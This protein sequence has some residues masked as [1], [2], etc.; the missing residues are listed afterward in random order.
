MYF[1]NIKAI[2]KLPDD[3]RNAI[4]DT[5]NLL[6]SENIPDGKYE[7]SDKNY[8]VKF[9]TNNRP[10]NDAKQEIHKEYIDIH[11]ILSGCEV[12]GFSLNEL[13]VDDDKLNSDDIAFGQVNNE[14]H[15]ELRAN[16]FAIF[17][18]YE[19][20]KPICAIEKYQEVDDISKIVIKVSA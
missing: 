4:T 11:L 9:K 15:I 19:S 18:P 14:S 5:L 10:F 1:G 20:H 8:F 7:L 17:Y 16:D 12:M 13:E 6:N 3:I 2:N